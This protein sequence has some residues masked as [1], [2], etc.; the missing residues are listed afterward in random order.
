M[1]TPTHMLIGIVV[2]RFLPGNGRY[3]SLWVAFGAAAPDIPLI[4]VALYCWGV[5]TLFP[6]VSE[7]CQDF[8]SFVDYFYFENSIFIASHHL[9]HSP[10]S[11]LLLS[12]ILFSQWR[13]NRILVYREWWFLTGATSHAVIDLF[14]HAEDGLLVFWPLNWHF[15]FNSGVSQWD[16][17]GAG[18]VILLVEVS[19]CIL[20]SAH[21][22]R[23]TLTRFV[24]SRWKA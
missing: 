20:F 7:N 17:Q 2:G 1:K 13:K 9:L 14:T 4:L 19:F 3:K 16:M 5:M 6:C 23:S 8:V 22:L 24:L 10:T 11:L 15:R 18:Q 12:A 21:F